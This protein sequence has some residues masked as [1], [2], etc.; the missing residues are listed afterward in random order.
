MDWIQSDGLDARSGV[1]CA[2][3]SPTQGQNQGLVTESA[4]V[5]DL[6]PADE[7][8]ESSN[9]SGPTT[10]YHQWCAYQDSEAERK[11]EVGQHRF[12]AIDGVGMMEGTITK[13]D[14]NTCWM[15]ED[16]ET[17]P[18]EIPWNIAGMSGVGILI[19]GAEHIK[20]MREADAESVQ[21]GRALDT[22]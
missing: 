22:I 8:R 3:Q 1:C 21:S 9:L 11:V 18:W 12:F 7:S 15:V 2:D 16:G 10:P 5:A 6:K 13:L 17:E 4:D 20:I 19:D 14:Q